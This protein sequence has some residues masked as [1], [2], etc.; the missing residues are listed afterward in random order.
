LINAAPDVVEF[1]NSVR[2]SGDSD[3][4]DGGAGETGIFRRKV[5]PVWAGIDFEKTAV[6]FGVVDSGAQ[7]LFGFLRSSNRRVVPLGQSK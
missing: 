7:K 2:V 4:D 1:A 5:E 6:C 3:L